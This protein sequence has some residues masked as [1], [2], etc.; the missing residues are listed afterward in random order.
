MQIHE[1]EKKIAYD[2]LGERP[3][4]T[5]IKSYSKEHKDLLFFKWGKLSLINERHPIVLDLKYNVY[6]SI[7]NT[8]YSNTDSHRI[9]VYPSFVSL[10]SS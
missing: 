10:P 9:F 3:Y 4:S 1:R 7:Y 8:H 6:H 2:F 5:L